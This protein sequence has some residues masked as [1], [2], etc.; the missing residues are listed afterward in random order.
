MSSAAE[1]YTEQA[2]VAGDDSHSDYDDDGSVASS[3]QSLTDSIRDHVYENGRRYHRKSEDKYLMPTDETEQDR[4]DMAHHLELLL[5]GGALHMAPVP[6]N[7]PNVLDCGTGTGIWALDFG[8]LHQ[9]SQVIGVDMIP[10][11][12]SWTLPNVKF[13]VDDIEKPWTW[14]KN[15]FDFIHMRHLGTSIRDWPALFKQMY[16]HTIPGGYVEIAEHTLDDLYCDDGS[17]PEES[18]FKRYMMTLGRSVTKM[19][20]HGDL[21]GRDYKRM[22]EEAGFVDVTV[23][24]FKVPCG[25]LFPPSPQ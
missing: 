23:Y 1:H 10:L 16:A 12:P 22:L 17:V 15:K 25:T 6:Q 7:A 3:T 19:G 24:T 8:E 20:A 21:H 11:Q 13:E 4:L 5:L 9:G 14:P 2:L 18:V